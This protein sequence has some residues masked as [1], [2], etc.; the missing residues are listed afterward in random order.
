M[1][2]RG[3]E[4]QLLDLEGLGLFDPVP[5]PGFDRQV[6]LA[7]QIFGSDVALV[8]IVEPARDRQV[9]KSQ[10]GLPSPWAERAQTP[11]SHSFCRAVRAADLP[12]V[13]TDARADPRVSDNPAI[14]ELGVVAYLGCPIH[15]PDGAAI[16][17][18]CLIEHAPRDWTQGEVALLATLAAG[19]DDQIRLLAALAERDRTAEA[20]RAA[21]AAKSRF[22][23]TMSHEIRTP[24]NSVLGMAGLLEEDL[25]DPAQR[26]MAATI[27]LSGESL[28]AVVN[29]VLD[30]AKIEAGRMD[31]LPRPFV[32]QAMVDRVV[33]LHRIGAQAKG[34]TLATRIAGDA[35]AYRLGDAP[36]LDQILHN[37]LGNSVKFT[38]TGEIVVD[39]DARYPDR[40]RLTVADTGLGLSES[41]MASLFEPF[42]QGAAATLPN[43]GG[44]GLGT[45]V[46]QE[47]V[48]LMDGTIGVTS[49]AGQGTRVE[50]DLPL[51]L[52]AAPE[53]VPVP[54]APDA[55]RNRLAGRRLLVADD[56]ATNRTLLEMILAREGAELTLVSDGTEAVS[57]FRPGAYD[58]LLLDI[59]MPGL[60]GVAALR[61]I[62][63]RARRSGTDP[64]P[65][66]AITANV[67]RE[68]I[69][70]YAD[71]GFACHVAKPFDRVG[72]V[73][74]ILRMIE[75]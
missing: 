37:L 10:L 34:L 1:E 46:V 47:L 15:G 50:I 65:A 51:A 53:G 56:T 41:E 66:A 23:A 32:P 2:D 55:R 5:D 30:L 39:L 48:R 43:A 6:A 72:L 69:A 7:R 60:D 27:R 67:M 9:F 20:A 3:P 42:V 29:D 22:V 28:L 38:A 12:L 74:D 54:Q 26:E 35:G 57:A 73:E 21:S 45:A 19:V 25:A 58:G 24:L 16:G 31:L 70:E 61:E 62:R 52:C 17:A 44:T 64:P 11:L 18:L 36:R 49:R 68:Q 71:A 33:A 40:L 75:R 63:A 14:R 8:S 4:P 13:V 59:S